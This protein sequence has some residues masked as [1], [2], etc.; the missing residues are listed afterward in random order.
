M[1]DKIS[2]RKVLIV[3]IDENSEDEMIK[4]FCTQKDITIKCKVLEMHRTME[5]YKRHIEEEVKSK[6][7]IEEF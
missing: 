3:E 1:K 2:N 4:G 7:K 5:T 6:Y